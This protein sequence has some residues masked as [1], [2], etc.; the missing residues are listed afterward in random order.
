MRHRR[1]SYKDKSQPNSPVA[2]QDPPVYSHEEEMAGRLFDT[3]NK[4][5]EE[6]KH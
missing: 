2:G 5:D 1:A 6:P 3:M 4:I